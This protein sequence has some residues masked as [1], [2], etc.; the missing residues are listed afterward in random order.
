MPPITFFSLGLLPFSISA[1]W[2]HARAIVMAAAVPAGPAPTTTASSFS[3]SATG[4]NRKGAPP[5][6]SDLLRHP[7][8]EVLA[9]QQA[10]VRLQ[11]WE[12]AEH[13]GHDRVGEVLEVDEGAMQGAPVGRLGGKHEVL[14]ED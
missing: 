11:R 10:G 6:G 7:V 1:T 8:L 14:E 5:G 9:Q 2:R 3:C 4:T 13:E 12:H